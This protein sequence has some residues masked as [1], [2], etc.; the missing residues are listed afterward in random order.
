MRGD[1]I[2]VEEHHIRAGKTIVDMVLPEITASGGRHTITVGGESGS[3][4]SETARAIADALEAKGVK[5]IILQQD[6][7]YVYPP[8][9]NDRTRREDIGW[10]GTG[11]VRFEVL[12]RNLKEILDGKDEI[13]KPLVIYGEDR[14]SS[15]TM[16]L[17]GAKVAIAEGTYTSLL[18]NVKT[19]VFIE[20][21]YMDTRAHREKR[22]RH[23]SELDEFVEKV[24]LI[25]HEIISA[26][27][28]MADIIVS[29]DYEVRPKEA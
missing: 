6:D 17:G 4:K 22:K 9:T 21:T 10:V 19:R 1:S 28:A 29:R 2:I 18:K 7:Y 15:E 14:I 24:L 23:E 12:D 3:G 27:K 11:E 25:E 16:D 8:R 5:S 13:E 26:H 20:R